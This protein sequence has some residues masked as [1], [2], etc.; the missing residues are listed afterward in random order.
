MDQPAA[1]RQRYIIS[2]EPIKSVPV[3]C[4]TVDSP[5]HLYLAGRSFV[6]THNCR[7]NFS[8]RMSTGR[9]SPDGAQMMYDTQHIGTTIPLNV[10]GRATMIGTDD[11]PREVQVYYT[12]DPR[13]A[14]SAED[15]KLLEDLK[16]GCVTYP[17]QR[18]V[19]GDAGAARADLAGAAEGSGSKPKKTQPTAD[20]WLEVLNAQL[21]PSTAH[22]DQAEVSGHEA[23]TDSGA[24]QPEED[25]ELDYDPIETVRARRVASN[26]LLLLEPGRWVLVTAVDAT[27]DEALDLQLIAWCDDD[28]N[29]GVQEVGS[30]ELVEVR[31][32]RK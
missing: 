11:V 29:E 6:A 24:I 19:L 21:V 2:V 7:D 13:R 31:R 28:D 32:P 16:P 25:C 30:F 26:M 9:L 20:E 12:P 23:T 8:A 17:R 10:R 22:R 4:I 1:R 15:L 14:T 3:R 18:V 27:D 5:T